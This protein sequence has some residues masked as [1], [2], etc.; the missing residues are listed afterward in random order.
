MISLFSPFVM[1]EY[2]LS[3]SEYGLIY[4]LATLASG[5]CL[6]LIGPL[7]D[8]ADIRK[9]S[10][11]AALGLTVGLFAFT[12]STGVI[13]LAL[14]L[15]LLR[16]FGQG[17]CSQ[18]CQVSVARYFYQNRGKATVIAFMG[19]SIGEGLMTP[20]AALLLESFSWRLVMTSMAGETLL[21]FAPLAWWL[22]MGLKN[23]NQPSSGSM[24]TEE[25]G[26]SFKH[27]EVKK[28]KRHREHQSA[29]QLEMP[30][31][32]LELRSSKQTRV[33]ATPGIKSGVTIG[34][35]WTRRQVFTDPLIYVIF[36]QALLPPF[37]L[38]GIFFYQTTIGGLK[39][40]A[41]TT[42]ALG[43]TGFAAMR[44]LFGFFGGP[45]VDRHGA[46]RVFPWL[47]WPMLLGFLVLGGLSAQWVPGL[48]CGLFGITVG[49]GS[50][51]K[52]AL[53]PEVYGTK[54]LGA[55]K[56]S[57]SMMM[58]IA[59]AMAPFLFGLILDQKITVMT[60]LG[61]LSTVGVAIGLFVIYWFNSHPAPLPAESS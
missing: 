44:F 24:G 42:M 4:S 25:K 48:A 39:G 33:E 54:H 49:I 19:F 36:L 47:N 1:A 38:T 21:L 50:S 30:Q 13:T 16:F 22:T 53:Y 59:T 56:S 51:V 18:V 57:V 43:F 41:P 32:S 29:P 14:S 9:F 15:F 17:L 60:L 27:P 58:V 34:T 10:L 28:G 35:Q 31:K 11:F 6:P 40:W 5:L 46:Y 20:L 8:R 45:L 52:A 7:L 3:K 23:F 37:A 2:A 55:I 26:K 12:Q 61:T